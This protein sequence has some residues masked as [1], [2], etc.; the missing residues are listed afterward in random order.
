MYAPHDI[1]LLIPGV[2][3]QGGKAD[4]VMDVLRG[5]KYELALVRINSSS[6]ITHGWIKKGEKRPRNY[7]KYC[8]EKLQQLNEDIGYEVEA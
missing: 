3:G 4:E 5:A 8:A 7:G 1:P 6:G 2:G